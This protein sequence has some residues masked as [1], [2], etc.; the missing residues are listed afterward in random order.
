LLGGWLLAILCFVVI[1]QPASADA[2][3]I[4]ILKSSDI[5]PYNQAIEGFKSVATSGSTYTE[6]DVQGDLERGRKLARKIRASQADLVLA[7]GLKAAL[8]AK[9]EIVDTPIIFCMVLDPAKAELQA[10][11][12]TGILIEVPID[13]QLASMRSVLPSLKRLGV[14]YD[15][16]KTTALVDEAYRQAKAIGLE[17]SAQPVSSAKDVPAGLR[18]VLPKVDALW[19][20]PDS[21][22]LTE[23]SIKFLLMAALE[24]SV[25]VI[26]FSSEF[27]RSGALL[28]LSVSYQDVG[29]QA[30]FL[31]DKIL[32]GRAPISQAALPPENVRLTINMKTAKYLGL[33]IPQ[34]I[35]EK[36][37]ETF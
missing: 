13:R 25:P 36:A 21:T 19:L 7:V 16:A 32:R 10:P 24:Q 18:A 22:V 37:D 11:N 1:E 14:L 27:V 2:R 31:A 8:A 29:E 9:L 12:M 3:E 5:A 34:T 23:D 6:Y 4:A 17:V 26:G 33:T 15:P 28:G 35:V 20:I 30:G